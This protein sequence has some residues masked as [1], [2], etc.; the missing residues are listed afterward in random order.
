MARRL[1]LGMVGIFFLTG[2]VT[3]G[4][5]AVTAKATAAA[6]AIEVASTNGVHVPPDIRFA[7]GPP[8]YAV[9]EAKRPPKID[10]KLDDDCWKSARPMGQLYL[11]TGEG[12]L[13]LQT[14]A[15]MVHDDKY[16][17]VAVDCR[18]PNVGEFTVRKGQRDAISWRGETIELFLH[19][20]RAQPAYV[21]VIFDM[22]GAFR[23]MLW[24]RPQWDGD[25]T[26]AT[27]VGGTGWR[28]EA[29]LR[30][31]DLANGAK[32]DPFLWGAEHRP[33]QRR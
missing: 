18:H 2:I 13:P 10:G 33:Q 7:D 11:D 6:P 12:P 24:G 22:S 8:V 23:D 16:L 26:A 14:I 5:A 17:Y 32:T 9:I 27:D 31:A 21:Q 25:I 3:T 30:M 15:R 29:K 28:L 1:P 19:A 4:S 20:N